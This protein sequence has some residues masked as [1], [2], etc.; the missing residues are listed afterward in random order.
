MNLISKKSIFLSNSEIK[1]EFDLI[2]WH[3]ERYL[4][5]NNLHGE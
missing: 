2:K 4:M 3:M 5:F 1:N